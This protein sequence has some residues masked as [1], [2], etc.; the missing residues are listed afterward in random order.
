MQ[1]CK[2][3]VMD[4][5]QQRDKAFFEDQELVRRFARFV[6]AYKLKN[7]RSWLEN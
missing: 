1:S 4:R 2:W 5:I 7:K 3:L 6:D